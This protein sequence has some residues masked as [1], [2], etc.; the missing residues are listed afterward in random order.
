MVRDNDVDWDVMYFLIYL[1]DEGLLRVEELDGIS[2]K[3]SEVKKFKGDI[4]KIK[5][6]VK[7]VKG[8]YDGED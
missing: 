5:R 1:I 8:M 6:T 3:L 7:Y 4:E 2:D